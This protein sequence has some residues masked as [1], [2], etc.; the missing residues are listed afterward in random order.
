[1]YNDMKDK[2]CTVSVEEVILNKVCIK[3]HKV[4]YV[5]FQ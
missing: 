3:L 2:M 5:Q 1:M 4:K